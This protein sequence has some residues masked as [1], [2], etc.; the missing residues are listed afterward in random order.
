VTRHGRATLEERY[1]TLFEMYDRITG[2]NPY[3]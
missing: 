3:E 1:G 2:D